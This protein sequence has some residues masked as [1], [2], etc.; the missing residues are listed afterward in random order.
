MPLSLTLTRALD[1]LPNTADGIAELLALEGITGIPKSYYECPLAI[2]LRGA[3]G[4]WVGLG[5][6]RVTAGDEWASMPPAVAEFT[7]VFDY[8]NKWPHL[9]T[10]GYKALNDDDVKG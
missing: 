5:H 1:M 10:P 8:G 3:V 6:D 9:I 4:M 7:S 2:H